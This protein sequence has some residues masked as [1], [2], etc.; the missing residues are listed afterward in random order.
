MTNAAQA[1]EDA[2]QILSSLDTVINRMYALKKKMEA[3][4]ETEQTLHR[5][6]KKRQEHLHA[7][8][9]IPS[10][11]DVKYDEWSRIRLNRLIIDYLLRLGF[12][13]SAKVL[14]EEKGIE[15]LVDLSVFVHCHKVEE[16]L[17][18][19]CTSEAL[20]WCIE[21]KPLMKKTGVM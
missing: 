1:G 18:K 5:Q 10:L 8:Y 7:L 4:H 17:R 3:L 16:S 21:H 9:K 2:G 12:G 11:V 15:D 6:L 14:A 20:A 19:G 13:E